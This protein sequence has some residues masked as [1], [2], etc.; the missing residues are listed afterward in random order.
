MECLDQEVEQVIILELSPRLGREAGNR[1]VGRVGAVE[2]AG[3]TRRPG[4]MLPIWVR[5][6]PFWT[7]RERPG[8]LSISS[9]C[10]QELKECTSPGA[11]PPAWEGLG[12]F[13]AASGPLLH[14]K[15][16]GARI[17]QHAQEWCLTWALCHLSW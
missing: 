9:P 11:R 3:L 16:V 13:V 2:S 7:G 17:A 5:L 8:L 12:F 10:S 14:L 4:A 6:C 1:E 15:Q